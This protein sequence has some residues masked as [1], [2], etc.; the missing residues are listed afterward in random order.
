LGF[1]WDTEFYLMFDDSLVVGGFTGPAFRF[2]I[3]RLY[4][5][6]GAGLQVGYLTDDNY[7]L[8]LDLYG[9]FPV[10]VTYY[11]ADGLGL[12][13]EF[14]FGWGATGV[15]PTASSFGNLNNL[16]PQIRDELNRRVDSFDIQFARS[17]LFDC[18]I[19]LRFP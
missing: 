14:G 7:D 4:F 1:A 15:R 3:K 2:H 13:F 19:G 6:I 5:S 11:V 18:A 9:R 17:G 12:M 16:P 8:G 10:S